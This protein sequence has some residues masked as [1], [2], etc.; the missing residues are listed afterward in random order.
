MQ[1]ATYI[2]ELDKCFKLKI[3]YLSVIKECLMN[4][5]TV[6]HCFFIVAM[7]YIYNICDR[8]LCFSSYHA[9]MHACIIGTV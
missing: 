1:L 2:K 5:L 7:K 9:Y 4:L 3:S 6:K 8:A